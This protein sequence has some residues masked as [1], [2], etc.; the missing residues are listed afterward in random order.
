M[1]LAA[2]LSLVK[3]LNDP[4]TLSHADIQKEEQLKQKVE[5]KKVQ[6]KRV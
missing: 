1:T 3:I 4:V 5:I 2:G 6:N